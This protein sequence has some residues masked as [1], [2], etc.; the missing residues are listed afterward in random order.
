MNDRGFR[1]LGCILALCATVGWMPAG[2]A[3]ARIGGVDWIFLVDT[4]ASMRG[5]GGTRDIFDKVKATVADFVRGA[6][7]G[8]SL[9]IYS[10]DEEVRPKYHTAIHGDLDRK[11]LLNTVEE[12]QANGKRTHTG[13]ALRKALER[14]ADLAA[15]KGANDRTVSI[16]LFSDGLEDVRGIQNPVPIPSN[17]ELVSKSQ[18]YIFFVSLGET[19]HEQQLEDFVNAPEL[20]GRGEVVRDPGAANVEQVGTRIRKQIEEPPEATLSVEPTRVD[21]GEVEPGDESEAVDLTVSSNARVVA[22]IAV[23]SSGELALAEPAAAVTIEPD[24][25]VEIPVRLRVPDDA[26][27]GPLDVELIVGPESAQAGA[28]LAPVTVSARV[29]VHRAPLWWKIGRWALLAVLLLTIV[30]VVVYLLSRRW[31]ERHELEGEIEIIHPRTSR[32]EETFYGLS[33]SKELKKTLGEI[34]PDGAVADSD[35][36]LSVKYLNDTKQILLRRTRGSVRVNDIEIA[37][38]ELY[39]GDIIEL[40][41]ARLRFNWAGHERPLVEES[42]VY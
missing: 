21:F 22:R 10:F 38:K 26:A 4:S 32:D 16:V 41:D 20:E 3:L 35:G 42:E 37:Q 34:V 25:R 30:L 19:E 9:T 36:E 7:E 23:R 39:D 12:L 8:D 18:P 40:G 27:D 13:L 33:R 15:Q 28:V 11:E 14:S 2:F 5:V 31:K 1:A 24:E 6:R 17:I 29:T